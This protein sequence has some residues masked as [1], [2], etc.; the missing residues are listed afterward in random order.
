MRVNSDAG[1]TI[2]I[3]NWNAGARL[4]SCLDS[5]RQYGGVPVQRIVV[6]DN[7]STD[8][9]DAGL[10]ALRGVTLIRAGANLGF[11]AACNLGARDAMGEYL[12]FLNPDAAL[13][14]RTL[15]RALRFM[16]E[17]AHAQVGIC[18]VKLRDEAGQVAR[19]CARFP[20][21]ASLVCHAVG[22]DR[23]VPTLGHMMAEWDHLQSRRVDHVIGAF[24]LVRREIFR[25]LGGFDERF[26]VY[27]EDLDFSLR[28]HRAGW[29][30]YYLAE[31]EAFHA[32]GGTSRQV[33]ARRLFYAL[34]S[35]LL[36]AAKHFSRS[37]AALV[38][39]ATL[40]VEPWSRTVWAVWQRSWAGLKETWRA[41]GMLL[42]WLPDWIFEGRT[43]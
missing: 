22:L 20:S 29:Q 17:P 25:A 35:R 9:S 18:G 13:Q 10:E 23:L 28:A 6:V 11:A 24:F 12:L 37:G 40:L 16:D 31:A 2:V 1:L 42:R 7:G 3:V 21:A 39:F 26:F 43:R 27:L 5:V 41:Y 19:S 36:Y 32:G 30:S 4:R 15:D 38:M 14:E 33:R 8:G 34:R